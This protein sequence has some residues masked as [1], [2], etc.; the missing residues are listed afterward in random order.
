MGH[1]LAS[2]ASTPDLVITSSAIR[3]LS[4]AELAAS[5]GDWQCEIVVEPRLYGSA[6]DTVVQVAAGAPDVGRLM[7]VGH[8]PTWSVLVSMLSGD[9]VE[10]KTATVAVLDFDMPDWSELGQTRGL[11]T[12]VYDPREHIG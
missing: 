7:L 4:T 8:Q 3:A 1:A 2:D 6:A 5:A 11:V 9:R 12:R 10:M